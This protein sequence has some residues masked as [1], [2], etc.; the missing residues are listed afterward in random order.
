MAEY[1]ILEETSTGFTCNLVMPL[2]A[3]DMKGWVI[4]TLEVHCVDVSCS[5]H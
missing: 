4:T 2:S 1:S 5:A 3:S